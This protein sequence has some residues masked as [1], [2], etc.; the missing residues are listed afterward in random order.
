MKILHVTTSFKP[1]WETGGVNR[2]AY[3]LSK[4]FAKLGNDVTV[5]TTDRG[6]NRVNVQ[7][8]VPLSVDG[9][10]VYYF[11]N[12]SNYF[13]QKKIATPYYL[14]IIARKEIKNF[15]IIHIHEHRTLLSV[16]VCHYAKK[17]NIPY[18]IQAHGSLPKDIGKG[19]LKSVFD[20]FWRDKI[21]KSASNVIALNQKEAGQYQRMGV[22]KR[23]I[24]VI[25]NGI[26][27]TEYNN[28]PKKGEFKRKY[29]IK[30][31][32]KII[33]YLG[34][35]DQAKGLDLLVKSFADLTNQL[36]NI[37]LILIGGTPDIGKNSKK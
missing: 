31:D 15:D 14:P 30:D 33:L 16:V 19:K 11:K 28:L 9:V 4:N 2:V 37:R 21:L 17:F 13:A 36:Q 18:I 10:K 20:L 23:R 6:N 27:L 26:D 35:L 24:E 7:K 34:R 3:E 1:A 25:P 29:G 32:E 5:Y 22:D 8:N 12:I